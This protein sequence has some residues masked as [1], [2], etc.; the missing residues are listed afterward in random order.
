MS[1]RSVPSLKGI[2][3]PL[4]TPFVD[5]GDLAS[6]ALQANIEK[7]NGEPLSG[8]VLGGSNGELNSLT[9]EERI[10]V[11]KIAKRTA[12]KGR[13]LIA[14]SGME[15]TRHTIDLTRRMAEAGADVALV[16]TPSYYKARMTPA[17]LEEH[18]RKVAD[19]SP[20]PIIIY[21]VPANTSLDMP[22]ASI[23]KLAAHTNIIGVKESGGD[24]TK[25]GSIIAQAPVDFQVLAGSASFLLPTLLL[26]GVGGV[27]ALANIA[28]RPLAR[29]MTL[30]AEGDLAG[31]RALQ[32]KLIDANNAVTARFG[33]PGLKAALDML[34]YHGGLARPPLLPLEDGDR[35]TLRGILTKA[36]ILEA[37]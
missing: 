7:L 32:L 13:L 27:V 1:S 17:V 16:V 31:A 36:G 33:V 25:I 9:V 37:A 19:A 8:Y 2:F 23:I 28:A 29:M 12:A 5:N 10:E 35:T 3:P 15:S 34:G 26:G 18:F 11:V 22:A 14:G 20:I 4:A 21:N 24:I 6:E 30:F